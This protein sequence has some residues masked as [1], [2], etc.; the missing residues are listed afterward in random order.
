MRKFANHTIRILLL[1]AFCFLCI[2]GVFFS[3][4]NI[5]CEIDDS[6]SWKAYSYT[7]ITDK[8]IY[9]YAFPADEISISLEAQK[10][11]AQMLMNSKIKRRFP[12]SW[13]PYGVNT[14]IPC[15]L[16]VELEND[17]TDYTIF[18]CKNASTEF[19]LLKSE[20]HNTS[21]WYDLQNPELLQYL[22]T[23]FPYDDIG[24]SVTHIVGNNK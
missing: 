19:L 4:Q 13:N 7:P 1:V 16:V 18:L 21:K 5:S 15:A 8:V 9:N 14:R 17:E 20:I 22:N 12:K 11:I 6:F 23:I 3:T 24:N 2:Y 10:E